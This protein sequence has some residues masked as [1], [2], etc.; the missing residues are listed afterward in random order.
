MT[1]YSIMMPHLY[2][3]GFPL[4]A[5]MIKVHGR[6]V[7]DIWMNEPHCIR[8]QE[9]LKAFVIYFI[10]APIFD[11]PFTQELRDKDLKSMK[12]SDLIF[13]CIEY[14]LDPF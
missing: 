8:E 6:S 1:D 11:N 12:L 9:I 10:N 4:E 14:G 13:L 2:P 3:A 5:K 7:Q